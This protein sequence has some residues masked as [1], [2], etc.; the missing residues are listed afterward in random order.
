MADYRPPPLLRL[1]LHL[2]NVLFGGLLA[3]CIAIVVVFLGIDRATPVGLFVG[4]GG[5]C[6]VFMLVNACLLST[7]LR[8]TEDSVALRLWPWKRTIPWAGARVERVAR[9]PIVVGVRVSG[10]DGRR[11]WLSSTWFRDFDTAAI[12]MKAVAERRGAEGADVTP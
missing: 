3:A 7:R 12:E 5:V 6:V 1:P 4:C 2:A 10:A 9:G 8:V 11:L